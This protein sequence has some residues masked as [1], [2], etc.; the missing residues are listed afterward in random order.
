MYLLVKEVEVNTSDV[1]ICN[2]NNE[3]ISKGYWH[4]VD[5]NIGV[6]THLMTTRFRQSVSPTLLTTGPQCSMVY[7]ARVS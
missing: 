3:L 2:V 7:G 5:R 6:L 1:R 4:M